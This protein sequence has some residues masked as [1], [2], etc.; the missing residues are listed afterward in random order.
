MAKRQKDINEDAW[1]L[2]AQALYELSQMRGWGV[3]K[4]RFSNAIDD[5]DTIKGV[6]N[7]IDMRARQIAIDKLESIWNVLESDISSLKDTY[8]NLNK[9]EEAPIYKVHNP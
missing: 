1:L 3:L 8:K 2:E 6:K 7:D 4:D 5:L 9:T